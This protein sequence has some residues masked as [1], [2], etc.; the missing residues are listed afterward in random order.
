MRMVAY[1]KKRSRIDRSVRELFL[2]Y[3]RSPLIFDAVVH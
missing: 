3:V 2:L 1:H